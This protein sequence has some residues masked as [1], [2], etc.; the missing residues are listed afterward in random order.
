MT[1]DGVDHSQGANENQCDDD[2]FSSA[3]D[4][5]NDAVEVCF[6]SQYYLANIA[7]NLFLGRLLLIQAILTGGKALSY[8]VKRPRT[9]LRHPG[10]GHRQL[11][12]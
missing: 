8:I 1:D 11:S 10:P 2:G 6:A 5:D 9:S 3:S 4:D 7:L 12:A